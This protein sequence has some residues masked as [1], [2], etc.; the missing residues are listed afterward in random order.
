MTYTEA[1]TFIQTL[2]KELT[3]ITCIWDYQNAPKPSIP[4]I[5]L[6]LSP[7][8]DIGFETRRRNDGTGILDVIS[9]K[10]TTLSVNVFGTGALE[11]CNMLWQKLQRP[12]IVD[13]CFT[14]KIAFIRSEQPQDL[15]ALLD[16]RSWEQ[17]AN[18]DLI[19]TYGRAI[20]DEPGYITTVEATGTLGEPDTPT[21][22]V[23]T[24]IANVTIS[25]KG[26]Q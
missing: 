14:A 4:Y 24:G 25:M 9:Q 18:V 5:S 7:E 3:A 17:R 12:T 6:R 13:R 16:G 15:T 19:V 21:P 23:D 1:K 8:R 22:D 11:I 2:I 10:E 26:V 20:I